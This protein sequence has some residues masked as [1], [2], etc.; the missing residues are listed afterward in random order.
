MKTHNS[1]AH[2]VA[3]MEETSQMHESIHDMLHDLKHYLP[4]QAPLKDFIHHNTLHAFQSLKFS[5]AV[6]HASAKFGYNTRLSI[7]EYRNLYD[8]KNIKD[9][10]LNRVIKSHVGENESKTW[11]EKLITTEYRNE[12]LPRIGALRSGWKKYY[13]IDLDSLV[14]PTLFRILCSY[15]DQGI[16]MWSFPVHDQGLLS[17]VRELER[18]TFTSFFKSS[19]ARKLVAD[20]T[21]TLQQLL[22]VVIGD[23]RYY[24][25]YMF[26]QQFAHQ[27]WSGLVSTIESDPVT[28]LDRK[29]ISLED[30]IKL[31]L[32]FEIDALESHFKSNWKPL[33]KIL[34]HK[35]EDLFA[36]IIISEYDKVL[37]MWQEAFE[38]SYYDEVLA[39]IKQSGNI[40]PLT[41]AK[42]FQAMFCIDDRE[43]SLHSRTSMQNIA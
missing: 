43:C 10:I 24:K 11:K 34:A 41:T 6:V 4:A 38:W 15:L 18:Y 33:A 39:A 20:P 13:Q 35:P 29:N 7:S 42:T 19:R 23:E 12:K 3:T 28:L 2:E 17:S 9:S 30:L 26:D 5:D 16:A 32:I 8:T 27:G 14:H 31:E 1:T 25:Q 21:V 36:P 40:K 22:S 37:T